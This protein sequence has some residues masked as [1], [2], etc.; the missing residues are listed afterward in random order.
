[1]RFVYFGAF[2]VTLLVLIYTI[3]KSYMSQKN[4]AKTLRRVLI[5]AVVATLANI[6]VIVSPSETVCMLAYS[7]FCVGMN[8]VMY[9]MMAFVMEYTNSENLMKHGPYIFGTLLFVDSVSM[10]CNFF[11][12]HAFVAREILLGDGEV[13][14]QLDYKLPYYIHLGIMNLLIALAIISLA[15]KIAKT[16]RIYRVKYI[17]IL[18]ILVL[19][20]LADTLYLFFGGIIDISII[21]FSVGGI[22]VYYVSVVYIPKGL[23]DRLFSMV[24]HDM[25]DGVLLFDMDGNCIRVNESAIEFLD[26]DF[27]LEPER[28]YEIWYQKEMNKHS[29][30]NGRD[31]V[32]KANGK[33]LYLRIFFKR[34]LDEDGAEIGSFVDIKDRTKE[35][36]DLQAERYR[37]SHDSLTGLY[38]KEYFYEK[39]RKRLDEQPEEEFLLI[40]SDIGDF[41]MVNDVFGRESGDKVLIRIAKALHKLCKQDQIYGRIDNDGFALLMKKSDYEEEYF[42]TVPQTKVYIEKNMEY[43][44]RLYLGV[45]EIKQK[46][47]PISGMYD[48]AKMAI[49]TIKGNY[50]KRLAYYDEELR[51]S[52]LNEQEIMGELDEAIASG[53]FQ[54]YLQAQVNGD[55]ESHGAEALV[56]WIHPKKGYLPPSAFIDILEKNGAIV[57]LDRYVWELACLKLKEWTSEGREDMYLSVNI[58]PKN[59]YF[60]DIYDTFTSLVETYGIDPKRLHLEITET[61]VMT[62]VEQRIKIIERLQAYGF[63]VEMDDFGSGYSSLNMLKE[64]HVN[65]LKVDMVFLRK[66]TEVERSRKILRT[67]ISLAQE[68]GMET[69][70]EGVETSD[71]LEFLKSISCDIFQGYYFA[72]P[73]EVTQFEEIYMHKK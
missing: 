8:W 14:Y 5:T 36:N 10:V 49:A 73:M 12:H 16:P 35:V 13:F 30:E 72:K 51:Q 39:V 57:R 27:R 26:E 58:S 41:K 65:V 68:L 33:T 1:M 28:A 23:V 3:K 19:V 62:D 67:I 71:Q 56:R 64:I 11:T 34:L 66:T 52:L 46:D 59:F 53:Q 44:I 17:S 25:M 45:Y 9:Y 18:V 7:V 22:L 50:Q 70:V 54:I 61:S 55:G 21:G 15:V 2:L 37:A 38:N 43:P 4:T 32:V 24:V 40:C 6:V 42:Q 60:V 31:T 63:I 29:D 48:R 47:L 69:I 20:G